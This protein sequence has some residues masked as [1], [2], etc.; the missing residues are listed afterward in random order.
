MFALYSSV[1]LVASISRIFYRSNLSF[2]GEASIDMTPDMLP[3]WNFYLLKVRCYRKSIDVLN[4]HLNRHSH[5]RQFYV[6]SKSR[7]H[8][9]N[10]I[11]FYIN[12]S[13]QPAAEVLRAEW[14]KDELYVLNISINS[15][16][17]DNWITSL[18]WSYKTRRAYSSLSDVYWR[19]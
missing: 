10:S 16:E 19:N 14:K 17:L 2:P 8:N 18:N 4:M 3:I 7:D 5:W 9:N 6:S 13:N 15:L 11:G 1:A 12:S